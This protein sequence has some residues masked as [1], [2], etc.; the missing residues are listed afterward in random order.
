M[1]G[2]FPGVRVTRG[3]G[4]LLVVKFPAR[5]L[6]LELDRASEELLPVGRAGPVAAQP[7]IDLQLH[8]RRAPESLRRAGEPLEVFWAAHPYLD[9]ALDRRI[10]VCVRSDQPAQNR[11]IDAAVS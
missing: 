10:E 7:R 9:A 5:W 4:G 2:T 6:S 11:G 8:C 1:A 3:G